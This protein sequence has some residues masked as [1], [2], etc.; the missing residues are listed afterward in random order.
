M[1]ATELTKA[2]SDEEYIMTEDDQRDELDTAESEDLDADTLAAL[3][4]R[5]KSSVTVSMSSSVDDD[6]TSQHLQKTESTDIDVNKADDGGDDTNDDVDDD[7][8]DEDEYVA[9]A[10]DIINKYKTRYSLSDDSE[11]FSAD[12]HEDEDGIDEGKASESFRECVEKEI[13]EDLK[14][15]TPL[16]IEEEESEEEGEETVQ[17]DVFEEVKSL[18]DVNIGDEEIAANLSNIDAEV[19][20]SASEATDGTEDLEEMI[21]KLMQENNDLKKKKELERKKELQK[22][23]N[24]LAQ[25]NAKLKKSSD[26]VPQRSALANM[27]CKFDDAV[28]SAMTK[29]SKIMVCAPAEDDICDPEDDLTTVSDECSPQYETG[30]CDVGSDSFGQFEHGLKAFSSFSHVTDENMHLQS[31]PAR[32]STY[33]LKMQAY[34]EK[35]KAEDSNQ[36]VK[37]TPATTIDAALQEARIATGAATDDSLYE[38][39]RRV[40]EAKQFIK[41]RSVLKATQVNL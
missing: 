19:E 32:P 13:A 25:E 38:A 21:T 41:N 1:V 39:M 40:E 8:L 37:T 12:P 3:L 29:V 26:P 27:A 18:E 4:Q 11:Q 6:D 24:D 10:N 2:P 20:E 28:T 34:N 35:Y 30:V 7:D 31:A 33:Q 15:E 23:I 22:R 36:P 5:Y 14:K 16:K 17:D 9:R